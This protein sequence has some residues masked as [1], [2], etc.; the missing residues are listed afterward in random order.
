MRVGEGVQCSD[1]RKRVARF[2][3]YYSR[4]HMAPL[5]SKPPATN[6]HGLASPRV[7]GS[8]DNVLVASTC[9]LTTP[10]CLTVHTGKAKQKTKQIYFR[11]FLKYFKSV[12]KYFGKMRLVLYREGSPPLVRGGLVGGRLGGI[13][14]EIPIEGTPPNRNAD[15]LSC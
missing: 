12:W 11:T 13:A 2:K 9:C 6:T 5:T 14:C 7:P 10:R 15:T 4:S 3:E 1:A 8:G